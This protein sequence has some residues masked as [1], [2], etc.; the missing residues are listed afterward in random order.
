MQ[1]EKLHENVTLY[2]GDCREMIPSLGVLETI[3]TDPPY[4]IK[5][6]SNFRKQK[7]QNIDNDSDFEMLKYVSG[8]KVEY[9]SYIFCR[10]E[11]LFHLPQP[12]NLISWVKDEW[13]MGDL[14]HVHGR[15]IENILFYR[16]SKHKFPGKR[17]SDYVYHARIQRTVHPTEKPLILME[18]ICGW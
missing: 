12:T 18:I 17:P 5:F 4:G 9:S 2:R 1:I 14:K 10:W 8:L 3:I 7:Y 11:A 16:G 13:G 15:Q 6:V